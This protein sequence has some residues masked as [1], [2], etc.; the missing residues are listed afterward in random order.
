MPQHT[1]GETWPDSKIV[2]TCLP[3]IAPHQLSGVRMQVD[4][5]VHLLRDGMPTR[6]DA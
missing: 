5:L 6:G 1:S 2:T 4:L 3:V